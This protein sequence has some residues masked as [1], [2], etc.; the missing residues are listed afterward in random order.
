MSTELEYMK[1]LSIIQDVF[2]KPLQAAVASNR[3]GFPVFFF[4]P[5]FSYCPC[6]VFACHPKADF[7]VK[8]AKVKLNSW[9]NAFFEF[10]LGFVAV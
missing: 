10:G 2:K 3:F 6:E 9:L 5:F 8:P 4:F 1:S 7:Y